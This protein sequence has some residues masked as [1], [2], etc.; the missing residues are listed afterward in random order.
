MKTPDRP[1]F[2]Y[3]LLLLAYPRR[4]RKLHGRDLLELFRDCGV[5]R[6]WLRAA[7]DMLVHGVMARRDDR[8][9]RRQR[10]TGSP[11]HGAPRASGSH[12]SVKP[13]MQ[14]F[15]Q[16]FGFGARVLRRNPGFTLV[17]VLTLA[18]GI[19]A[20][21]AIFSVVNGI[22]LRPLP[23]P[24]P[25]RLVTLS[26]QPASGP[27]YGRVSP[28]NVEDWSAMSRSMEAIG[29]GRGWSFILREEDGVRGVSSGL[30]TPGLFKVFGF[31]PQLGRLFVDDDLPPG[32]NR[33]VILTHSFWQS[34]F[35]S[36]PDIV[37]RALPF[38]EGS[39]TVIGVL[40]ASAEVPDLEYVD[41]WTP[42][43][44]NPRDERNRNWRGFA[45]FGRLGAGVDL[46]AARREFDGISLSLAE[47]YPETNAD[48]SVAIGPLHESIVGSVRSLLL[49]FLGA[50]GFVLLIGCANVANLLLARA[51]GR[52]RE[53][54]VRAALGAG[55][56]RIVRLVLSESLL[57][58]A[59]GGTAGLVL[60]TWAVR[61]FVAVAPSDIPRMDEVALDG[62]VMGFA[63]VLSIVTSVIFGIVP[64]LHASQ[65]ELSHS[66]KEGDQFRVGRS[67]L[68]ARGMLVVSEIALAFVLLTGA[69]LLL[70]SFTTL[71]RWDPGFDRSNLLTLWTLAPSGKYEDGFQIAALQQRA[72]EDLQ[73]IPSVVSVG[74]AS[75]GPMF[76]GMDGGEMLIA[77]RPVPPAGEQPM[78]RWFD[79]GPEYFRTLRL[80]IVRGRDF[81]KSDVKG[82][83]DVA[84]INEAMA[85]KYWP[86]QDPIGEQIILPGATPEAGTTRTIVGVVSN[87]QP[88]EVGTPVEPY[89]YWPQ[90]QAPR[91]ATFIIIRTESDPEALVPTVQARLQAIEPD[92]ML[93]RFMTMDQLIAR[94][95]VRPRFN[96]L[97]LGIF[98]AVAMALAA[99]GIYGVVSYSV[100]NRT[101][102]MG[103][104][105]AL[106]AGRRDIMSAVLRHGMVPSAIG[107]G[108]GLVGAV[109]LTRV[110][111]SMLYG[112]APT[113]VATFGG[114]AVLLA[115]IATLACYMPARRA[116]KVD[117][118]IAVKAE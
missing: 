76:G 90:L 48:W 13:T 91:G 81:T 105:M 103:I 43:H 99:I 102:E 63:L 4:F 3:R 104:R 88:F 49:V 16:D 21:T 96:M 82:A 61:M 109:G 32:D 12:T 25:G 100:A 59:I 68:G 10:I 1:S 7:P 57:L 95:V 54:A 38:T 89:V 94:R 113:D 70:Q 55:R 41:M 5:V 87:V 93:S 42:L 80:P 56:S 37:G 66:L 39:Y 101:R 60:A 27:R 86:E 30:A 98:A 118:I 18:L 58:A 79:I 83:P 85:R 72:V 111:S 116:T 71:M 34:Q 44:F 114:V 15:L 46:A 107:I 108:I 47:E 77:G 52:R 11:T 65:L 117:P 75:A 73:S 8:Q 74:N 20:N 24:D 28:P 19:G 78:I 106:G 115:L 2:V 36:D 23:Y 29:L 35:G 17:A 84:I 97:L 62:S 33:V 69:G 64:S 92:M 14:S 26:E 51:A 67:S 53:F 45:G 6:F 31:T 22:L 50:V 9:L 110:L 112:V 40:P